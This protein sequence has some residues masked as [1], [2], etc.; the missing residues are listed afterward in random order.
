MLVLG[1]RQN[2]TGWKLNGL[3]VNALLTRW[4]VSFAELSCIFD[5]HFSLSDQIS[6]LSRSCF[7]HIR[8][9]C[10]VHPYLGFI[11][12]STVV[13]SNSPTFTQNLTT[14]TLSI[15]IFQSLR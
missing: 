11:T 9:L 14:V 6:S 4:F 13:I 12:A 8:E 1:R 15:I 5:E 3:Q 2:M 10:C 7:S